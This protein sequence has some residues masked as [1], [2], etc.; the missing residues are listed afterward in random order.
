MNMKELPI[1]RYPFYKQKFEGKEYLTDKEIDQL[2]EGT[3][4][5]EEKLDGK[6]FTVKIPEFTMVVPFRLN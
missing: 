4:Y 3:I 6:L 5:I 1:K 2:F